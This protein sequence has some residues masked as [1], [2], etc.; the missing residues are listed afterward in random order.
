M[1]GQLAICVDVNARHGPNLPPLYKRHS[2]PLATLAAL[3]LD[4][5]PNSSSTWRSNILS[6]HHNTLAINGCD[7]GNLTVIDAWALYKARYPVSLGMP[8][9]TSWNMAVNGVGLT[10]APKPR[11]ARW[12]HEI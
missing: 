9:P 2:H 11:T 7:H 1:N 4:V 12:F 6:T 8:C 3:S 5:P 10:P